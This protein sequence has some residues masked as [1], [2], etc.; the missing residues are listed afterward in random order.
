MGE[1]KVES[2]ENGTVIDHIPSAT[3]LQ[4]VRLVARPEDVV[5]IG[6]NFPSRKVLGCKGVVKVAD[7]E[8]PSEVLGRLA[9]LAPDATIN[10]I[11]NGQVVAKTKITVPEAFSA[12]V[13]CPN[14]NCI[15]NRERWPTHFTVTQ[16]HPLRLRC[17]HCE[18]TFP[19]D[20]FE[21]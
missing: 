1:R 6:I 14:Q 5:F 10:I 15:T 12:V 4:V 7:R 19:V 17:R 2:I 11:R 21:P 18:R 20:E 16:R 8:V 3:T 13:R 9:L